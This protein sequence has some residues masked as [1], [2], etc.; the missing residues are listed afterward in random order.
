MSPADKSRGPV[1]VVG[2]PRSG[3]TYVYH[4]L[5]SA[6]LLAN[7]RAETHIFNQLAP[8]FGGMRRAKD[9]E[10]ALRVFAASDIGARTN[11]DFSTIRHE[12][13]EKANHAGD[14]MRIIMD[15]MAAKQGKTRWGDSTPAHLAHMRQIKAEIPDAKFVHVIRDGRD[16]AV[17]LA[18]QGWVRRIWGDRSDP[19]VAAGLNWSASTRAA[20]K[21][22]EILR[23]DYAEVRYEDLLAQPEIELRKLGAFLGESLDYSDVLRHPIGSVSKPNSSFKEESAASPLGRWKTELDPETAGLLRAAIAPELRLLGYESGGPRRNEATLL[24]CFYFASFRLKAALRAMPI[25]SSRLV[26]LDEFQPGRL[27]TLG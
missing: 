4:L 18:R 17:S 23:P 2:V 7:F 21:S 22:G 6:G 9:R 15:A 10:A 12:V 1:F 3:T 26:S 19:A 24:R 8:R 25:I 13:V 20:I 14:F 5:V 27:P 11:V 16:V